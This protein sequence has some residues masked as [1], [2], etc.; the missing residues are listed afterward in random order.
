M[1]DVIFG[2]VIMLDAILLNVALLSVVAPHH[3]LHPM[4]FHQNLERQPLENER[5]GREERKKDRE[6]ERE[7][8]RK[9][10]Y[11]KLNVNVKILEGIDKR[12]EREGNKK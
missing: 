7:R 4:I 9:R 8:T 6:R 10:L 5:D 2:S 1:L 11:W 12:G 3:H